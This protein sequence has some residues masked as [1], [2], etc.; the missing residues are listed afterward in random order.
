MR[1]GNKFTLTLFL[2]AFSFLLMGKEFVAKW[3]K[4]K[5]NFTYEYVENDPYKG[6]IYTLKNGLKVFL[7]KNP[8]K[9]RIV[10]RFVVK[11][12][13]ADSPADATGLAHYLEHLMFKGTDKIGAL[14]HKKEKVLLN[15]IEELYEQRR[16]EKDPAKKLELF[17]KIDALSFQASKYASAGEYS[18]LAGALGGMNLNAFTS[19]DITAY[20]VDI[21]SNELQKFLIL[22]SE[23]LRNPVIRL[24]HTELEAVYQEFNHGQDN[25]GR[26]VYEKILSCLFPT[27]PYGWTPLIGKAKHLREPSIRLVK[28]FMKKYYVPNNMALALTGDLDYDETIRLVEKYFSFMKKGKVVQ[29]NFPPEKEMKENIF[30]EVKG[31]DPESVAIAF[32]VKKGKRNE[33]LGALLAKVLSNGSAGL[34]DTELVRKQKVLSASASFSAMRDHSMLVLRGRK[35][36][37]QSLQ[38]LTDLL[39]ENFHKVQ[40][41]E[42]HKDILPA[43]IANYRKSFEEGRND[44]ES[45]A[46]TYL[47]SFIS[48]VPY[49]DTLREIDEAARIRKEDIISFASSLKKYVRIWKK[50]G[51]DANIVKM[52]KPPITKVDLN[53]EKLSSFGKKLLL[54][55][56]G[57]DLK[58]EKIDFAKDISFVDSSFAKGEYKLFI[59]HKKAPANDKLFSLRMI[60]KAGSFHDPLL[61]VAIGYLNYLGTKKY[62]ANAFRKEFYKNA[63]TFSFDCGEEECG[64]SLYGFKEKMEPAL[65]LIRDFLE[66]VKSDKRIYQMYAARLIT[67]KKNA[68]RNQQTVFRALN[69]YAAY[70]GGKEKNPF[71]YANT[72]SPEEIMA[73]DPEKLVE[74]AKKYLGSTWGGEKIFSYVGPHKEKELDKLLF[75]RLYGKTLPRKKIPI[76]AKK[77]FTLLAP[78]KGNVYLAE[79]DSVQLLFGIRS[80]MGKFDIEK[81]PCIQLFNQYFGAGGLD[82]IVFSEIRE[83]RGLAYSAYAFYITAKE[84]EKHNAFA[85][86]AGLQN[87]K[88]FEASDAFFAL[89]RNLPE[90]K[91]A[92]ETA[93]ENVIKELLSRRIYGD[94][95]SFCKSNQKLGLS[96]DIREFLVEK[97][98]KITLEEL[99]KFFQEEIAK[100][101]FDM[102]ICGKI[103]LLDRKKLAKYGSVKEVSLKELFGY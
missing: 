40:K 92:F 10:V 87:D 65:D 67:A 7:A 31:P 8:V 34:F 13:L 51:V 78:G 99:K 70:G 30:A 18:K 12:G 84:K 2:F 9:P 38:E 36:G 28:S 35:V 26:K 93:K 3:G 22:E 17:K 86:F 57:K 20:V 58:A 14:D 48:S 94:L 39:L 37:K 97:I 85:T 91:Q 79:F 29:R 77:D 66:N 73:L 4:D 69:M 24:F 5:N 82:C 83:A 41:G 27:H 88:F 89:L 55:P 95:Y 6:R 81:L 49:A 102:Y 44:P 60:R 56:S 52:E 25:D 74:K 21:P 72:L 16:K 101:S 46:W 63:L 15:K 90:N 32:R 103:S 76:A 45:A 50:T 80:R 19:L 1:Y 100:G 61:P 42:F 59:S 47:D 23:R 33:L 68:K 43:V 54:L 71:I 11:A 62:S 98:R 96:E 64:F 75:E 53:S